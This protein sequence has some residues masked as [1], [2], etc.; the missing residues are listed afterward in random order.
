MDGSHERIWDLASLL[1]VPMPEPKRQALERAGAAALGSK[2][3]QV[4]KRLELQKLFALEEIAPRLTVR[5]ADVTTELRVMVTLDVP[6]PCWPAGADD[7][8]IVYGAE[9][10]LHY[11][12]AILQGPLPG[13]A[14]VEILSPR[15]VFHANVSPP[16]PGMPQRL[17]L[18][19]NVPRGLPLVEA[20]LATYAA[21]SMQSIAVDEADP[22]GV[23]NGESARW[24]Q[25]NLA[26]IPLSRTP[27]L[28]ARERSGGDA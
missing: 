9:L 4:R 26:R 23:M 27:F 25:A 3:W 28:A 22:A 5:A 1:Q 12:E 15:E 2:R 11:P 16:M 13:H 14:V 7:L 6:V 18:G 20:V 8:E 19:A 21:F 17:C 10:V 24:W